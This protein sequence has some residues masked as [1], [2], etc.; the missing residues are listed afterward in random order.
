MADLSSQ[1][2]RHRHGR[3]GCFLRIKRDRLRLL[4]DEYL[5]RTG[6]AIRGPDQSE[7]TLARLRSWL[8]LAVVGKK[9]GC[10]GD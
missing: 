2:K 9:W 10:P 1:F 5:P 7:H 3:P 6:E 8:C 4:S